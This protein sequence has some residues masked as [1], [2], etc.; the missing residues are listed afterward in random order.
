MS[1]FEPPNGYCFDEAIGTGSFSTV[2]KAHQVATGKTVAIKV[3]K[4]SLLDEKTSRRFYSEAR[5][6]SQLVHPHIVRFIALMQ[7]SDSEFL[8]MEYVAGTTLRSIL[9]TSG[10]LT[11][12][13]A[14]R[15]F[16]QILSAVDYFHKTTDLLHRDLKVDNIMIDQNDNVRIIDF[17]LAGKYDAKD[18][19]K[20]CGSPSMYLSWIFLRI[21]SV[22]RLLLTHRV[23]I[24]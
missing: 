9:D 13:K 8:I 10:K 17:G 18:P 19:T 7:D 23:C 20:Y 5:I 1:R 16:S 2:W 12:N 21:S 24:S 22:F 14:R 11:E 3:V 4:R 15:Y 6:L